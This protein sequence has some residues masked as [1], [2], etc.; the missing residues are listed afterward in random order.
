MSLPGR[1]RLGWLLGLDLVLLAALTA[2]VLAQ[3]V[4]S[5]EAVRLRNAL[6]YQGIEPAAA[7]DWSPALPP[8]DFRRETRLPLPAFTAVVGALD[9]QAEP[10]SWRKA[11]AIARHLQMRPG[12]GSPIMSGLEDTYRRITGQGE[13]YCGDFADVFAALAL[14]AGIETRQWSFSFDGYGGHG[15]IFNEVWDAAAGR[16]R[17]LDVFNNYLF[18]DARSGEPLSA[19]E[20]RA[21]LRGQGDFRI[22]PLT[23]GVRVGYAREEKAYDYFR[24]G[25]GEWYLRWGNN[26]VSVEE[27]TWVRAAGRVSRHLEQLAGI[28]V[29]VEP[30][31]RLVATPESAPRAAALAALQ[32]RLRVAA[33]LALALLLAGLGLFVL[34][35]RS[36]RPAAQPAPVGLAVPE[37]AIVGP[38]PPPSG[39]MANQCRQLVRLLR[40][41][42]VRVE[43]VQ[44][45]APYRP[46][47]V[48]GVPVLR[49]AFR[50]VPYLFA[51]WRAA[52][53]NRLF[54]IFAN[55][56]WAWHL[57]AAP[58]IAIAH[59][60]G[61]PVIVNYRGGNADAFLRSAPGH[62][63]RMLAAVEALVTPSGFLRE[64]FAKHR[65]AARI[66]P[67]IVDLRRFT[68]GARRLVPGAPHLVVTRNLETIYDIP[69]AIRCFAR[70]RE[71]HP[72]A[73]LTVAG[74]GPERAACEGLVAELG[75]GEAVTFAG[76]IDN[77]HI[78]ALYAEADV[79]VNPSTVDN[80]PIS[81]LEAF[82]SGVP[83]VT[84][85][86][87]GIPFIAEHERSALLVPPGD[88]RAMA[89]AVLRLL[90]DSSL[91]ARLAA[92]GV[93]EARGYAWERVRD[94]WLALYRAVAVGQPALRELAS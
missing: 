47:W 87:G 1:R 27:N 61:V 69:T 67:N 4:P 17:A 52:G 75:L 33:S 77:D 24:R 45:N 26:L 37:V 80:M 86:V 12:A 53:R 2:W 92:A 14:A 16:W 20:F 5:S 55:S 63:R 82:A 21:A 72:E 89:D 62:V 44:T 64:V 18:V 34:W 9:L 93:E 28:V 19:L 22:V 46:A 81:I 79:A 29:G 94:Q 78:A 13:G 54:H 65:L 90:A 25:S 7:L 74:S 66:V 15:H 23:P 3:A 58:A 10:D 71:V 30:G 57:F 83:V 91:A 50:L 36:P 43:L 48:G 70:V 35:R 31:I 49:A 40:E 42:G 51:L 85:D 6:L 88:P 60:R 39:G 41:E 8:A 76:R 56:G 32:V 11:L 38:L 84:T 73:R 59:W 68:P